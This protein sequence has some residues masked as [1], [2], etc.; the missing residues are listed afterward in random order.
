MI[1]FGPLFWWLALIYG[2][3]LI[4]KSLSY[5]F[6]KKNGDSFEYDPNTRK[7]VFKRKLLFK[8]QSFSASNVKELNVK[9]WFRKLD[10]FDVIF[11]LGLIFFSSL[12]QGFGWSVADSLS[13]ILDNTISSIILVILIFIIILYIC[14]PVDV[15]EIITKTI[16]HQIPVSKK[17]K[18]DLLLKNYLLNLKTS[19]RLLT[20]KEFKKTFYLRLGI[21]LSIVFG[22]FLYLLIYFTLI[23]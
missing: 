20:T 2:F 17:V 1:I 14:L 23:F 5:D 21:A 11:I 13:L 12:Q 18:K 8:F 3:I 15:I 9:K 4:T 10:S 6:N 16:T 19:F 7:F 22:V